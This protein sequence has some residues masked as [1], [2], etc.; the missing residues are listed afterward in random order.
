MSDGITDAFKLLDDRKE[1]I[2]RIKVKQAIQRARRDLGP[3][4]ADVV[5]TML[6][7]EIRA[8]DKRKTNKNKKSNR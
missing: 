2:A 7:E 5:F 8:N 3:Y 1:E 4:W 6:M